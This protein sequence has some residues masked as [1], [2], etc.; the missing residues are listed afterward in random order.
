MEVAM[1][2]A[3][4]AAVAGAAAVAAGL[5]LT[6]KDEG[7]AVIRSF[8]AST[9][10]PSGGFPRPEVKPT[11]LVFTNESEGTSDQI[12]FVDVNDT[13]RKAIK[14]RLAEFPHAD[15]ATLFY[16][17]K[18]QKYGVVIRCIESGEPRRVWTSDLHQVQ[19]SEKVQA[20][21]RREKARGKRR[22]K[23]AEKKAAQPATAAA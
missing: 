1:S 10:A 7:G 21:Y 12:E 4:G 3:S 5:M 23:A 22:D 19:R 17:K 18:A 11:E 20:I 8:P 6:I 14:A 15:P 2:N 13:K 9:W 16:S